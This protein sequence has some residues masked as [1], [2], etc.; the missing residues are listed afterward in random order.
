M[1]QRKESTVAHVPTPWYGH[2]HYRK[3]AHNHITRTVA[4]MDSCF[5]L[6][7]AYQH[8]IASTVSL[9]ITEPAFYCR[10]GCI[11][12]PLSASSTLNVW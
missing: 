6:L 10:G 7:R 5:A 12:T 2:G 3:Y 9:A 11:S 1:T 4:A 8:G